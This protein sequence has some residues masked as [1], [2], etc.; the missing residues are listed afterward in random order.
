MFKYSLFIISVFFIQ[1]SFSQKTEDK[2]I[3]EWLKENNYLDNQDYLYSST[4]PKSTSKLGENEKELLVKS[5]K[6]IAKKAVKNLISENLKDLSIIDFNNLEKYYTES[7]RK[8]I[9]VLCI[10]NKKE[11]SD[12][13]VQTIVRKFENLKSSL[14]E[15]QISGQLTSTKIEEMLNNSRI[16][17]KEIERYEQI[18]FQ[19]NP[20]MDMS[21][22]NLFKYDID[23][24]INDLNSRM[25]K[26]ILIEKLRSAQRK[27]N[28]QD[29]LGAY[30]AFKDLQM[31]YPNNSE[32]LSGVDESFSTLIKIYDYRMSQFELNENYDAAIKTVDSLIKLDIELV[33]KYSAKLDDLRKRKFYLIC[34]KIEKLLSYKTVSGEQLKSYMGQLKG[35]NDIDPSRHSKIKNNT[36]S[37]LLEYDLKL[38]RSDVY[39]KNYTKVLS[40]IPMLK[41]TY[42]RRRRIESFEREIDRKMY[43]Y[44][45]KDLLT[46]RPR[47][48]NFEASLLLMSPPTKL[49]NINSNYYNLNLNYSMAIYRRFGI[50]PKNKLGNFKYSIIGLKFDY[51]DSK[52]TINS[53]DSS[54]Y[55]RNY[56][57]FNPQLSLGIRKF[58]YFDLGYVSH[59]GDLKPSLYSS[60]ISLFLPLGYFSFGINAKYLT[61]FNQ[62]SLLM[63]GVGIKF[64]FG[65]IKK[66][67]SNDKNEI[68]T[69]ILKLKQ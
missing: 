42:D 66:F 47:L 26:T 4:L 31:E 21:D 25:D 27:K 22:I 19:L 38:I 23:G 69:S 43:R 41:L 24:K 16:A 68:Q 61:D 7:D 62:S 53:N 32:V 48:Y 63:T 58:L 10:I 29:Y 18:A 59:N 8:S 40:E 15:S 60:S 39:N 28:N 6:E 1:F 14:S 5:E 3:N 67:N 36:D 46:S 55:P 37:R 51:L 44:F 34:D 30:S 57:F 33:K 56:T 52:Q 11:V 45:K 50:K 13:L 35:L 49:N 2:T 64:N 9:Q 54:I 17:R 12:Y 20:K 65:L